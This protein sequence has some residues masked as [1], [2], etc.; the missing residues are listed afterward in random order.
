MALLVVF[1]GL[2]GSGK[3]VLARGV[4]D[5]IGAT[6]L[7]IDTIESAIVSTLMPYR[8]NPVGYVVA[9]R[10]AADQL[11]A[12]RDV[13]ADAVNGVAAARAGWVALAARTGAALRFAEV[14]C[15]DLAEHRRRVQDREPEMPGHGVP[16]WEQVLRRRYEPWPPELSGRCI[17]DNIGDPAGHVARIVTR[18]PASRRDRTYGST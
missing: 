18:L 1:A 4:A 13:V 6:Y 9:E 8:D 16:T 12:G 5:A 15:S 7:R 2:P 10:V 14:R 11:I 3:S 17:I